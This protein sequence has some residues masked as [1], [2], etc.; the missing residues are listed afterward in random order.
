MFPFV[1]SVCL[2]LFFFG[3][4]GCN[5]TFNYGPLFY[6]FDRK[7]GVEESEHEYM[8]ISEEEANPDEPLLNPEDR[9]DL[10][11]PLYDRHLE[12]MQSSYEGIVSNVSKGQELFCNYVFFS[13]DETWNYNI[14]QLR[15]EC[16]GQSVGTVVEVEGVHA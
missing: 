14:H 4:E 15:A 6:V 8:M 2:F 5:K 13:S 3:F 12:H 10:F 11:D 16:H 9:K 7:A 1:I